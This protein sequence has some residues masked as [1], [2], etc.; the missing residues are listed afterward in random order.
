MARD[1]ID[2]VFASM[3]AR[4]PAAVGFLPT[5]PVLELGGGYSALLPGPGGTL[6]RARKHD[7][8]H[9]CPDGAARV[10]ALVV[11]ALRPAYGLPPPDSGWPSGPWRADPRYDVPHGACA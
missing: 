10:G 5:A 7:D 2:E 8:I 1:L 9:F 4:D 11:D 3:S 6:V